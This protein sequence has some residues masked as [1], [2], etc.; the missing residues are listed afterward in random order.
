M[1]LTQRLSGGPPHN[2]PDRDLV[3]ER[4]ELVGC[5]REVAK[6]ERVEVGSLVLVARLC[7][8]GNSD[9]T[10]SPPRDRVGSENPDLV[11]ARTGGSKVIDGGLERR[12]RVSG[13]TQYDDLSESRTR[14]K[15]R[16]PVEPYL[17]CLLTFPLR[18]AAKRSSS[19]RGSD[20]PPQPRTNARIPGD[21]ESSSTL[22]PRSGRTLSFP[23]RRGAAP[24]PGDR[25]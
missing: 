2:S 12:A 7:E 4:T 1:P 6:A 18:I 11:D 3:F 9:E 8:D 19:S 23:R 10:R 22:T 17:S 16:L 24:R 20:F 14:G 15:T 21:I 25:I 5:P 13:S